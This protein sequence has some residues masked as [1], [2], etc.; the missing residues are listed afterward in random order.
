MLRFIFARF[1]RAGGKAVAERTVRP[2]FCATVT[3]WNA[4]SQ[5]REPAG[6]NS[7]SFPVDNFS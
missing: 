1:G 7:R 2:S 4:M 3:A 5:H 6:E